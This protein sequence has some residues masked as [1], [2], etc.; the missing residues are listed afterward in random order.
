NGIGD[1]LVDGLHLGPLGNQLLFEGIISVIRRTWPD[2][3]PTTM[4][5][6]LPNYRNLA[7]S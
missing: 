2:L 6:L 4:P 7:A 1:Y 5:E 3:D